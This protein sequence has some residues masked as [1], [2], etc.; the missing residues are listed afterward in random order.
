MY[1]KLQSVLFCTVNQNSRVLVNRGLAVPRRFTT[2]KENWTF[3]PVKGA[4]GVE[5]GYTEPQASWEHHLA[6]YET[7]K[8]K[9]TSSIFFLCLYLLK[10]SAIDKVLFFP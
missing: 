7:L 1:I 10:I 5:I 6:F 8:I 4:V 2:T 3:S 9:C